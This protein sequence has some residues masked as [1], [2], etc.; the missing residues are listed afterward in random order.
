MLKTMIAG[1]VLLM[2][3]PAGAA[4]LEAQADA[5]E[6]ASSTTIA[7]SPQKVWAALVEPAKWWDSA[8]TFSQDAHNLRLEPRA[9]GCF[10]ET[11]PEGGQ[12]L[13]QT[14]VYVAPA[15]ALRLRGPLGPM[16]G[17]AVDGVLTWAIKPQG[18]GVVVSETYALSGHVKG[19]AD[20]LAPVVDQVMAQQLERLKRFVEAGSPTAH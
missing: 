17:M 7:A 12:V 16:Q 2:A 3:G 5:F 20:K 15:K 9:G 8:H 19:G 14:V 6:V 13:H 1:G 18:D 11:L 10:C 4:V